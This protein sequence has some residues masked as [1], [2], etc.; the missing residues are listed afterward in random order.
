ML[1]WKMKQPI[2]S[3]DYLL[4]ILEGLLVGLIIGI[5]IGIK[6]GTWLI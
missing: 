1:E 3:Q 5:V 2:F 4:W 6:L